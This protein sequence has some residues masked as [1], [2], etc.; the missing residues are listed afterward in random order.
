MRIGLT[1]HAV[2]QYVARVKPAFSF[3]QA[4]R[5]LLAL[6]EICGNY[7]TSETPPWKPD[8]EDGREYLELSDGIFLVINA[9]HR[10]VTC[11]TNSGFSSERRAEKNRRKASKRYAKRLKSS[12]SGRKK[13]GDRREVPAW[14]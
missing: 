8:E 10:A 4:K 13:L 11:L 2:N 5:E 6:V 14:D 9:E 7:P 3:D 1:E 12:S